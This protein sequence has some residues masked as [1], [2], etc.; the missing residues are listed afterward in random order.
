M[1]CKYDQNSK[2]DIKQDFFGGGIIYKI[3]LTEL[4]FFTFIIFIFF[5]M[6]VISGL[7]VF[8]FSFF[9]LVNK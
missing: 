4:L 7:G 5:K 3:C 2:V 9:F 1:I 6:Q 8:C